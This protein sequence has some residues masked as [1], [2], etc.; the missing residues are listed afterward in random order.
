MF[1]LPLGHVKSGEGPM[2]ALRDYADRLA[3]VTG[4]GDGIGRM[5]AQQ[6]A[7]AG[8]RVAV[9]DIRAEAAEAVAQEIGNGA[10]RLVFDVSERDAVFGASEALKLQAE[11]LSLLWINAGV[12]VGAPIINGKERD[13]DWA[14][15]VNVMGAIWTAQAFCPLMT[16]EIGP[17]HVGITA[18]SASLLAPEGDFPLY[19]ATKHGTLAVGEA[20]RGEL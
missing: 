17:R 13:V 1:P 20:L 14:Y 18:S 19:A 8:M 2:T 3:L 5:L 15:S 11:P 12:G 4:A 16:D 9:Q 6:L 7:K 10:F